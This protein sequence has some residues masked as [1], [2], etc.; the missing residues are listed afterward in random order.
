MPTHTR[1]QHL[2]QKPEI[3]SHRLWCS[4]CAFVGSVSATVTTISAGEA[5]AFF[6]SF[7]LADWN[8]RS[9]E[10]SVQ[11]HGTQIQAGVAG[12]LQR[13]PSWCGLTGP[14]SQL[15]LQIHDLH[16]AQTTRCQPTEQ[17]EGEAEHGRLVEAAVLPG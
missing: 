8:S 16:V 3:C 10:V 12:V 9:E 13:S 7:F 2:I 4:T 1:I 11:Q 17:E 15:W 14:G 5:L 6:N